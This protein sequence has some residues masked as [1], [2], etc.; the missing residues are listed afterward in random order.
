MYI[1]MTVV[2]G[3]KGDDSLMQDELFGPILPIVNVNS[4]NEAIEFINAREKPLTLYLFSE[5]KTTKKRFTEETS[6]GSMLI[7][8]C[9]MNMNVEY[10]PFGGVGHSGMGAYHGKVSLKIS[11][12]N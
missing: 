5:D 6:S 3:V 7:N 9:L 12:S 10:L 11:I 1:D 4:V 8:E 2:S